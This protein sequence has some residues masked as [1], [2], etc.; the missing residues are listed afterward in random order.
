LRTAPNEYV[1][2]LFR[3][4]PPH[5]EYIVRCSEVTSDI[6]LLQHWLDNL[7]FAEGAQSPCCLSE[8][9]CCALQFTRDEGL[10]KYLFLFMHSNVCETPC[11]FCD[12]SLPRHLQRIVEE[13][14]Y[15]SLF[16]TQMNELVRDIVNRT[17]LRDSE[18]VT[19]TT[20]GFAL[21]R[22]KSNGKPPNMPPQPA[23]PLQPQP[24]VPLQPQTAQHAAHLPSELCTRRMN[25]RNVDLELKFIAHES[26]K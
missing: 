21:L 19:S 20:L 14:V 26:L 23:V 24:A 22:N 11:R 4:L 10:E 17:K 3:T 25:F 8:A 18:E 15:L 13:N 5:S 1:L 16:A 12:E 7:E 2:V 9:L 6:S